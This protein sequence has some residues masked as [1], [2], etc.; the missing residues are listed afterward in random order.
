MA[1]LKICVLEELRVVQV[2]T[3]G[4]EARFPSAII[5]GKLGERMFVNVA[6]VLCN[7]PSPSY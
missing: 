1:W 5:K 2:C 7:F 6:P 4:H 3:V